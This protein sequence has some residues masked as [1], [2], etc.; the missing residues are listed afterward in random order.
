VGPSERG[1]ERGRGWARPR[2][3]GKGERGWPVERA[4]TEGEIMKKK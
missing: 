1:G 4:Q 2:V 3:R